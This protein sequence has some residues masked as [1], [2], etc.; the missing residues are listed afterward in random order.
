MAELGC[1]F[2]CW[3]CRKALATT[4]PNHS[5]EEG[6]CALYFNPQQ[7]SKNPQAINTTAKVMSDITPPPSSGF[8]SRADR[9]NPPP[10]ETVVGG[11]DEDAEREEPDLSCFAMA[12]QAEPQ[13]EPEAEP[14]AKRRTPRAKRRPPTDS[15]YED[16]AEAHE[17]LDE[18]EPEAAAAQRA[19][20]EEEEE[21]APP[22]KESTVSSR[23]SRRSKPPSDEYGDACRK[24]DAKKDSKKKIR[25]ASGLE[26]KECP[27]GCGRGLLLYGPLVAGTKRATLDA[28]D[29]ATLVKHSFKCPRIDDVDAFHA[30]LRDDLGCEVAQKSLRAGK[31]SKPRQTP[32]HLVKPENYKES[33]KATKKRK[34][35]PPSNDYHRLRTLQ[36]QD[37]SRITWFRHTTRPGTN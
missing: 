17:G 12:P 27:L 33:T 8:W 32:N 6:H 3:A 34:P 9:E 36:F 11:P 16:A 10:V 5:R 25:Y 7:A 26:E 14:L 28:R 22:S 4:D 21:E 20:E 19:G 29:G 31:G 24:E 13:A 15:V 23:P 2:E 1:R 30:M 18:L 37:P 35:S